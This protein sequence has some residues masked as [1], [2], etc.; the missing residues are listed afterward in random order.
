MD[1]E[2]KWDVRFLNLA[3]EISQ[4]SKDPSTKVGAIIVDPNT[5][6]IVSTG[7]NGFPR[8][9]KDTEERY[10]NRDVKYKFIVHAEMNAILNALYNGRS[11]KNCTLFVH[12]L[13]VCADCAKNVIASGISRIVIDSKPSDKWYDSTNFAFNLF[14]EANID[15]KYYAL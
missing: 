14:K 6:T 12:G 10:N 7:Y 3:K 4:W 11:V 2:Y 9:I 13:P 15:V 8:N 5:R 1:N